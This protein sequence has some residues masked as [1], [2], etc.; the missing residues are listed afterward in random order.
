MRRQWRWNSGDGSAAAVAQFAAAALTGL[1]T[2]GIVQQ[3]FT[4]VAGR[5]RVAE[6]DRNV[7]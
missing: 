5:G 4:C 1:V 7:A 2:Y 6:P 3:G